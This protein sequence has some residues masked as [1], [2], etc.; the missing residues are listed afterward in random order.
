MSKLEIFTLRLVVELK[1]DCSRIL[2]DCNLLNDVRWKLFETEQF[3]IYF[4]KNVDNNRLQNQI[5]LSE[6]MKFKYRFA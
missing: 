5:I 6:F 2:D 4:I 3:F 1:A